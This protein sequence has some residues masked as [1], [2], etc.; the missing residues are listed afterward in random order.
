MLLILP[1]VQGG[2]REG[3][4]QPESQPEGRRAC[5]GPGGLFAPLVDSKGEAFGRDIFMKGICR[6]C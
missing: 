2:W 5:W 4:S 1:D 3:G 6:E